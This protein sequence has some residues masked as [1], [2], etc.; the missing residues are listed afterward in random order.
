MK[1]TDGIVFDCHVNLL[2]KISHSLTN[3]SISRTS[4]WFITKQ[5]TL[6]RSLLVKRNSLENRIGEIPTM[7]R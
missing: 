3:N 6:V 4:L 1:H 2:L 7:S 5:Q